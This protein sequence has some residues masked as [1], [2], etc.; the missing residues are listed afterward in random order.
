M[1]ERNYHEV[2][3]RTCVH[4]NDN[5]RAA[6]RMWEH[7][8]GCPVCAMNQGLV[9]ETSASP[10]PVSVSVS[11]G[12]KCADIAKQ[13]DG[14]W[15]RIAQLINELVLIEFKASPVSLHT[16]EET[17]NEQL[18]RELSERL[19]VLY[20]Y[21]VGLNDL[22]PAILT[23]LED[24]VPLRKSK[25][26][27]EE[28]E[29]KGSVL[30]S[31]HCVHGNVMDICDKCNGLVDEALPASTQATAATQKKYSSA[32][33]AIYD[34][35]QSLVDALKLVRLAHSNVSR[36]FEGDGGGAHPSLGLME[37]S[38]RALNQANDAARYARHA[39]SAVVPQP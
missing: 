16:D 9:G 17:G 37:I 36:T 5:E 4:H 38:Q 2:N 13:N 26:G 25:A 20:G 10:S 7:H 8:S 29:G 39:L 23:V 21:Q 27:Q 3:M 32:S 30:Q 1:I 24:W 28:E 14:N 34:F 31:L 6:A 33:A 18:A 11:F 35:E 12:A 22:V 19:Q 15:Q